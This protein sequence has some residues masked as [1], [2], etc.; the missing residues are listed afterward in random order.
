[1][2]GQIFRH[3]PPD[4]TSSAEHHDIQLAV[5]T[6]QPILAALIG[7]RPQIRGR[8]DQCAGGRVL[9]PE[10]PATLAARASLASW[11]GR[12]GNAAAARDQLAALLPMRERVS[13]PEH[14]ET[15]AARA[16]LATWTGRA[17]DAASARDQVAA[18]LPVRERVLGP[19]HPAT[20][21]ARASLAS[22][23]QQAGGDAERAM[24]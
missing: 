22:W 9:G 12:A 16:S 18:L 21:A 24:D 1:M 7:R 4:E 13:G 20:L 23:T 5:P 11:T 6:H 10:H 3:Q 17:G 8:G 19:G 15:L 2:T 14:P